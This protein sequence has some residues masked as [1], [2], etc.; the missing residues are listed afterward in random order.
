MGQVS[1]QGIRPVFLIAPHSCYPRIRST[2]LPIYPVRTASCYLPPA[3]APLDFLPNLP[4]NSFPE[5]AV[6]PAASAC[7]GP[8]HSCCNRFWGGKPS[9]CS[10]RR[11]AVS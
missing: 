3:P 11:E 5:L 9:S 1:V 6:S 8:L 10:S 2:L 7:E 4:R